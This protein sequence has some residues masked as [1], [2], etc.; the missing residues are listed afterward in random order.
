ME[1]LK[2]VLNDVDS[3]D[4]ELVVRTEMSKMV[5]EW[6]KILDSLVND[7]S[8]EVDESLPIDNIC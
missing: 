7:E 1:F 6:W 5:K 4:E 2:S 3:M 8:V